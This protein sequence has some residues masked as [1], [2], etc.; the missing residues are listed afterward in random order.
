MITAARTHSSEAARW[1]NRVT[2]QVVSTVPKANGD[3]ERDATL[4]DAKKSNGLMVPSVTSILK[5]LAKPALEAWKAE[6]T[7]L[8]VLTTPRVA[9]EEMDAF[10]HRVLNVEQ[11][12][13]QEASAA[14]K[15]GEELHESIVSCLSGGGFLPDHT[16]W[17]LPVCDAIHHR[18]GEI[19]K[20]E[21]VV[22]SSEGYAGR[23]DMLLFHP[24]N[25]NWTLLDIKTTKKV[26]RNAYPEHLMQASAYANADGVGSVTQTA[27]AYVSTTEPG[28]FNI[29][30]QG[31][32]MN[33]YVHGFL[34]CLN[35]WKYMNDF[36]PPIT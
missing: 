27:I 20:S 8:A 23:V 9:G 2:R 19:K 24:V 7:A 1:Y 16:K 34:P 35:L 32:W 4:A 10:I 36:Y 14:A 22:A 6:Q 15:L 18:F 31:N 3:G 13:R 21:F 29:F 12:Q 28:H 5:V 33:E 11:Q 30:T 17:I 25:L 26:P